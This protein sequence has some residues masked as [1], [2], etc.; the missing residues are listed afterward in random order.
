MPYSFAHNQ[1]LRYS[2][3]L[4]AASR[5]RIMAV[6]VRIRSSEDVSGSGRSRGVRP[7]AIRGDHGPPGTLLRRYAGEYHI[8]AL[9]D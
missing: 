8:P 7:A 2:E 3:Y 6:F 4:H 1:S 9:D 5:A